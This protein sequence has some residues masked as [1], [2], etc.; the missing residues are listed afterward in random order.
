MTITPS[1]RRQS[2]ATWLSPITRHSRPIS[3]QPPARVE[4]WTVTYSRITVSAPTRT[5]EGVPSL[6]L[7]SW[8]A[9]RQIGQARPRGEDRLGFQNRPRGGAEVAAAGVG[10]GWHAA[11]RGDQRPV[12]DGPVV[13]HAP[14][15]RQHHAAPEPG[16]ARD[17]DLG[18]EDG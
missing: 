7:R 13:R 18:H 16:A 14:L 5:P 12:A 9:P 11:L 17:A 2:C 4:R 1:P 3:V 15:A 10:V 8:G 6:Y